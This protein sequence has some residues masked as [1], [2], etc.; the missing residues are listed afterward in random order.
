MAKFMTMLMAL[1]LS[2]GM[3]YADHD[4]WWD[5]LAELVTGERGHQQGP[6]PERDCQGVADHREAGAGSNADE[7]DCD[8]SRHPTSDERR[9]RPAP[10]DIRRRPGKTFWEIEEESMTRDRCGEAEHRYEV[11]NNDVIDHRDGN[12]CDHRTGQPRSQPTGPTV[13]DHRGGADRT[14][15]ERDE[16]SEVENTVVRA[17]R[18]RAPTA[19]EAAED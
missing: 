6:G 16:D 4:D 14:G 10:D 19:E 1:M 2:T 9:R 17:R 12:A 8:E 15:F 11:L 5:P 13:R 7:I 18:G 3:A